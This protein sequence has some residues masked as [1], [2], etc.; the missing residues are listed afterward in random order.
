M[1]KHL[2]DM[3]E[4]EFQKQITTLAYMYGW[5][6]FH[7]APKQVRPGV[8]KSDGNGFPDLT[9]CKRTG[10][11][12]QA[13]IKTSRG[14]VSADQISWMMDAQPWIECVVWRPEDMP[15]I[16]ERL[17]RNIDRRSG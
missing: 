2:R 16:K 17:A 9:M 5:Q 13:E 1:T 11:F 14:R 15:F 10:G 4:Q 3:S 12:I 6:V 8:W 7:P